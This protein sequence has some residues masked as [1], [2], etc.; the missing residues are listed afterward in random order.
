[1]TRLLQINLNRS[2]EAQ[3]LLFHTRETCNIDILLV[4]VSN[5][6]VIKD[7]ADWIVDNQLDAAIKVYNK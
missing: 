4:S 2:R 3:S 6:S 7:N 1:M 5:K